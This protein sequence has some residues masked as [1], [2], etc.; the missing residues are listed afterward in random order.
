MRNTSNLMARGVLVVCF[1]LAMSAHASKC[2]P[3]SDISVPK[4][5]GS[6]QVSSICLVG[7]DGAPREVRLTFDLK[8]AHL[9]LEVKGK[10]RLLEATGRER[11]PALV[12]ASRHIRFLPN[13]LQTY[14]SQ[15]YVLFV[16]SRRSV[17]GDGSG[18]C[19][20]GVEDYLNVL[21]FNAEPARVRAKFLIGSC[22][23]DVELVDASNFEDF[24]SFWVEEGMLG[25]EFLS[26]DGRC[27][28]R[29]AAVLEGDF[30]KLRFVPSQRR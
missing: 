10:K 30:R 28:D 19:G 17:S 8:L 12:G 3:A 4:M 29:L 23:D 27:E 5:S 11:N 15:G 18:Q 22:I 2:D 1:A 25:M 16:S 26:Y 7:A 6:E 14:R 21:D 20:S 9:F 24:R 13:R